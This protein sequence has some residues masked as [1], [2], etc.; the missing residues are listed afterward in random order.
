M[1]RL[2]SLL[3]E[4]TP[5]QLAV[6]VHPGKKLNRTMIKRLHKAS[7][8][9]GIAFALLPFT[10]TLDGE[11]PVEQVDVFVG[12]QD[13]Y[14]TYRIPSLIT[15]PSGTVLAFCEG[16][17]GSAG[18][19]GDIDLV[20]KRSEDGGHTWG[21]LEIVWDDGENTCGNP[22]PVVDRQ[23]GV[24]WLLLTHN[25]GA[26]TEQQIVNGTSQGPR[27]CWITR[28]NDDGKSWSKPVEITSQVKRPDWT[29][30]ATGPGVGIQLRNGRLLVPCDNKVAGS[31][32][33][34]SHVIIS[35]DHGKSWRIGGIVG[36]DCNESQAVELSDG[37]VMLNIR[38]YRSNH[39]R[40]VAYSKDGGLTFTDPIEDPALVEPVCQASILRLGSDKRIA[41]SNPA[42][43]R[44]ENM[45]L[46]I[47]HDDGKTWPEAIQLYP[48]PSAYSCLALLPSGEL[49]C[50][51][52][53]G[54][55]SPYERI[56]LSRVPINPPAKEVPK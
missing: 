25:F 55:R 6:A 32:I 30:Y 15:T 2:T 1:W 50:L 23:T 47:S 53:R 13:G 34:Q 51:Y 17:K 24:I 29:W 10:T 5:K 46:R 45:T 40:L 38:S 27:T 16:R 26:D 33:L 49:G 11:E 37:T 44:R 43:R 31:K 21:P 56:V 39:R 52:E 18:D 28:S 54:T 4:C 35:D 9:I 48:G 14:H 22:C 20:L 36:P 41:F 19:A 42:S 8:A 7:I 12:G 3:T